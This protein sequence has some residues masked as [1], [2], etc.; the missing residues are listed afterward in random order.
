MYNCLNNVLKSDSRAQ[1]KNNQGPIAN[2][3]AKSKNEK[4]NCSVS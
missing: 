4:K 1:R 2:Y 3:R